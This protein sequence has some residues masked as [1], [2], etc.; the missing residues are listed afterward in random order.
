M[1]LRYYNPTIRVITFHISSL[2]DLIIRNEE[3]G[4][5]LA[6]LRE[7]FDPVEMVVSLLRS[8]VLTAGY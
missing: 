3:S 5:G 6:G 2:A 1:Q 4:Q 7:E 8:G